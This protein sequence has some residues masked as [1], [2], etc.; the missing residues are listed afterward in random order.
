MRVIPQSAE[1]LLVILQR[2]RAQLLRA[3]PDK[4]PGQW[5]EY[6][7]QAGLTSFVDPGLVRGTLHEGFNLYR[8]LREPLARA[9]FLLF[10]I[11]EVHP[12]D[13]GNGR[14]ARL[15]MNAEL[16]SAGEG[17]I[18]ITPHARESYLD[19]LRRLSRQSEPGLYLRMLSGAQQ[20]VADLRPT[21]YESVKA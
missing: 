4:R 10:M 20:F 18:I 2:R 17:R 14:L 13:D 21:S 16:V 8:S 19:A 3:R 9:L 11:S 12:F 6:A 7:N 5:K 15:M 1:D